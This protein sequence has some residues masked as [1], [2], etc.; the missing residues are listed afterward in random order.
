[1]K[2]KRIVTED[3]TVVWIN[4]DH[5]VAIHA[6]KGR[7]TSCCVVTTVGNWDIPWSLATAVAVLSK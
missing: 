7:D 4:V 2:L 1:M 3:A 6:S 5:V